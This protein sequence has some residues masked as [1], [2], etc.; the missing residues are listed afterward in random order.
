MADWIKRAT[1][2]LFFAGLFGCSEN[3]ASSSPPPSP[4]ATAYHDLSIIQQANDNAVLVD[5]RTLGLTDL[6]S[7]SSISGTP[8]QA[9]KLEQGMLVD[10]KANEEEQCIES[11]I[12]YDDEKSREISRAVSHVL[13]HQKI[14]SDL[15]PTIV[16]VA[17]QLVTLRL[18]DRATG[19]TYECIIHLTSMDYRIKQIQA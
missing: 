1:V 9:G 14:S 2:L 17:H 18:E 7:L 5:G 6:S 15:S 3:L 11:L 10:V 4:K 16:S 8:Q 13:D 19:L 12:V